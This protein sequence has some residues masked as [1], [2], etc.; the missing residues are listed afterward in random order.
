MLKE[1]DHS[2]T[3]IPPGR[4]HLEINISFNDIHT[5]LGKNEDENDGDFDILK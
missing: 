2:S 3:I 1:N 4:N 5:G